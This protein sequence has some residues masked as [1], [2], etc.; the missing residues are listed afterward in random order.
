MYWQNVSGRLKS[1]CWDIMGKN[2]L[3]Y[4]SNDG[5]YGIL[6]SVIVMGILFI[7]GS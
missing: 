1:W 5:F 3:I 7:M 4:N 6:K 2:C